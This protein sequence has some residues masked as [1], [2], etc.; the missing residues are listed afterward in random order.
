M[1]E[2]VRI[3]HPR[4]LPIQSWSAPGESK[5]NAGRILRWRSEELDTPGLAACIASFDSIEAF[6]SISIEAD[7]EL[8][9]FFPNTFRFEISNDGRVWEPILQ[10]ADYRLISGKAAVWHFPLI[11]ARHLKFLFLC[12]RANRTGKYLAAFGEFRL[13][14]SGIVEIQASSELDRLW[15][16]ENLIDL[17][18][19]Y[20]WSSSLRAKREEETLL[21]DLGAINRL[22]EIRLLSKDDADTFFPEVFS[23]SY[24]EDNIAWHHLIEENGFLSEAAV[25]Y[26]WRFLPTNMRYVRLSIAEGARTREG[27][28]VSQ[29]IEVEFYASP[30]ALES[31]GRAYSEPIHHASVLRS[32]MVR[33]AVDGEV[34]EGVVVQGS[35]RRLREASTE[36]TGIVELASDGEDRSGVAVQG[37]DRRLKYATEDLPGIVRLAR[38][39]EVRGGHAVQSNDARLRVA[40]EEQPGLVEL[41]ADSENRP[42]VVVQ[43]SDSRLRL[44]STKAPGIVRLAEI[45]EDAPNAAVQGNDH[46]LRRATVEQA[47]IMRFAR[48]GENAA[49]AAVQANDPRLQPSTT[50]TRGIVELARD[51]EE[52]EGVVVQGSDSRLRRATE[53]RAG[54]VELAASGSA[55]QGRAVQADDPRLSDARMP[56]EHH[57]DYAPK[58]HDFDSHQGLIRLTSSTGV[59]FKAVQAAPLAHA[60]IAG[61]NSGEGAGLTGEGQREGV[62]GAGKEAGVV[63]LGL[64][65][66]GAGVVGASREGA[67]GRF[68]SDRD[69]ALIAGGDLPERGVKGG[70]L[71]LLARGLVAVEGGARFSGVD[72]VVALLARVEEKDVLGPGDLVAIEA[73]GADYR[74]RK[75]R[76]AQSSQIFGVIVENPAIVLNAQ[77]EGESQG[78]LY[79]AVAGIARIRVHAEKRPVAPGDLLCSSIHSGAAEKLDQAGGKAGAVVARSLGELKKGEGLVLALLGG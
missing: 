58:A 68:A 15:V 17:R 16:K 46:R 59:A 25:W 79:V 73:Q 41:A 66:D 9:D 54:I 28:F 24:S 7:S 78:R 53:E 76:D 27:K 44:A 33:L 64:G 4:V 18:P 31:P 40:T 42:G 34:R 72:S 13:S 36:S 8:L 55:L 39:G 20:G 10:E 49:E 37:S 47:G 62:L 61:V 3:S 51:G 32:G 12:G 22:T 70:E 69:Y 2:L 29:I 71:A 56:L 14:I 74:L 19:E 26:R 63:G 38:D 5:A 67:G 1:S 30:D 57:H 75:S 35:D 11:T 43:G 21:F 65:A 77:S 48:S 52:R 50:E 45:G 6:N 23:F 60:P